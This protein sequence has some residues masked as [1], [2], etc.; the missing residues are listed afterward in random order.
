MISK[1][2]RYMLAIRR[3]GSITKAADSLFITQSALSKAVKNIERQLGSPLFSRIG[4]DLIPTHI[5]NRYMDYAEKI[6][7]IC[8][9]WNSECED[10]LGEEKGQLT[11]AVALMRGSCLLP[12]VLSR[13]YSRYPDVQINLLEESH[14]VE[15]QLM[16]SP[17]VDFAIYN[18]TATD[19]AQTAEYLGQEEIVL[20]AAP[21]HPLAEK[22]MAR[23]GFRYPWVDIRHTEH[24]PYILHPRDQTTGRISAGP[25]KK[26]GLTPKVLLFTRNSDIAIRLAASGTALCLAPESYVRKIHFYNPP[27]C[28]SVGDPATVTTLY[29][30]YQKGRYIPSYGRYFIELVKENYR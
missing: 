8:S 11:I 19:P 16:L 7:Q 30:V 27:L 6:C 20:V 18:S 14:S 29:A 17:N 12:D 28:F 15:K 9:D 23:E 25:F 5:G 24:E 4:N 2:I 22:A 26:A 3:Y 13:F 10:L 1:E 21:G